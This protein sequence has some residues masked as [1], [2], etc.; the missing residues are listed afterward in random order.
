M[1]REAA[2]HRKTGETDVKIKLNIDG[3]GNASISTGIG[4]FDHMLILFAKH[5][6]VD[7]EVE[8]KG[9]LH[10]DY[11][12][13]VEDTGITLGQAFTKAMS[14]KK[15]IRRYGSAYVPMDETLTRAVIDFSGRPYLVFR[16]PE[17][18]ID[19]IGAFPFQLVEEFLRGFSVHAA[20]N[21]HIDILYGKDAH[22][23]AE[24]VFKAMAKATDY[25]CTHD[26]R[27]KGIP[28]TKGTLD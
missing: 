21:L 25:A 6:L 26:P 14:D 27:V 7:L 3:T 12:H 28:S 15:G 23:M 20:V 19:S 10:I 2:I 4:F 11:H 8:V 17:I 16:T 22:H 9:D 24:S 5:A 13:T 18:S 1:V